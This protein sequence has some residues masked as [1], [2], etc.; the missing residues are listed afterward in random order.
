M[1]RQAIHD[2][3]QKDDSGYVNYDDDD[4]SLADFPAVFFVFAA[5]IFVMKPNCQL[6]NTNIKI[7]KIR[8]S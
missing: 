1:I 4:Q 3:G 7:M 2:N 6:T 8:V 5:L